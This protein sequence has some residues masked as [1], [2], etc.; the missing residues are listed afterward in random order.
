MCTRVEPSPIAG[1]RARPASRAVS[2][3]PGATRNDSRRST[4]PRAGGVPCPRNMFVI[5]EDGLQLSALLRTRPD[6]GKIR[7]IRW[8]RRVAELSDGGRSVDS[9]GGVRG[10]AATKKRS[11][12]PDRS[13]NAGRPPLRASSDPL[14]DGG[15]ARVH[16]RRP[17]RRSIRFAGAQHVL[18]TRAHERAAPDESHGDAHAGRA[19][20]PDVAGSV[21]RRLAKI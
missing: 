10:A 17:I 4:S 19:E 9:G 5:V 2:V 18:G 21:N 14:H 3:Q 15:V 8:P 1:A 11:I 16:R 6:V 7:L 13:P 20:S 12:T